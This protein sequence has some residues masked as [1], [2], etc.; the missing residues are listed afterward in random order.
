MHRTA[1]DDADDDAAADIVAV[2]EEVLHTRGHL[3][4]LQW[5]HR[6]RNGAPAAWEELVG[7]RSPCSMRAH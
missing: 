3:Q 2:V 6:W 5:K 1:V 7:A 4:R